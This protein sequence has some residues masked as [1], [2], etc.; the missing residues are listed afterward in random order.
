MTSQGNPLAIQI[1]DTY[2]IIKRVDEATL[3][4]VAEPS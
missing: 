4:C 2:E 3:H 1:L